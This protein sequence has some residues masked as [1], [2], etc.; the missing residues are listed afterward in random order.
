MSATSFSPLNI[1]EG[2]S[3]PRASLFSPSDQRDRH[4][5]DEVPTG[6]HRHLFIPDSLS[7]PSMTR[8]H[9]LLASLSGH[10]RDRSRNIS[11]LF[12]PAFMHAQPLMSLC[13]LRPGDGCHCCIKHSPLCMQMQRPSGRPYGPQ[14]Q[15]SGN[16]TSC[17]GSSASNPDPRSESIGSE[18]M[19]SIA[20]PTLSGSFFST[21]VHGQSTV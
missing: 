20:N 15:G 11:H 5:F 21:A 19:P 1:G 16:P 13:L 8:I 6:D 12:L 9:S 10:R 2:L 4:S 7:T 18:Q 3:H 14:G 17:S